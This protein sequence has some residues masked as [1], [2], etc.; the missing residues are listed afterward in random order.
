MSDAREIGRQQRF[1][2]LHAEVGQTRSERCTNDGQE[3]AFGQHLLDEAPSSGSD[4]GPNGNFPL[5]RCR[6]SQQEVG[7]IY[8]GQQQ[9]ER[10]GSEQY[11]Q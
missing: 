11:E 1:Q 8:T 3:H 4:G 7:G 6:S 2:N 5:P 9:H 10:Y